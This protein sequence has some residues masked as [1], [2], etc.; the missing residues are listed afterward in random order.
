MD[1][2]QSVNEAI[3]F[4]GKKIND[5]CIMSDLIQERC[6]TSILMSVPLTPVTMEERVSMESTVSPA[7]A[8]M[9][10]MTPPVSLNSTSV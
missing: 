4:V 8:Q 10:I 3:Q 2:T 9:A 1:K 6:V 5:M 7:S